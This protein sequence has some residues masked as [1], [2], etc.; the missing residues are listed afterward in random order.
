ML[1]SLT[2]FAEWVV[3]RSAAKVVAVGLLALPILALVGYARV[4][5][6]RRGDE[7]PPPD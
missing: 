1:D 2:T 7:P 5:L 6:R 4:V 3:G